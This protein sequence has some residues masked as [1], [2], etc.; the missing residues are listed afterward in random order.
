MPSAVAGCHHDFCI[1]C[2]SVACDCSQSLTLAAN[3]S[4]LLQRV[5]SICEQKGKV[6]WRM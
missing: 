2:A 1:P 5:G 3:T 6:T 4:A